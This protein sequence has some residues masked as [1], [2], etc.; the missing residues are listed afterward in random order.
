MLVA[1]PIIKGS[2]LLSIVTAIKNI[3]LL[4]ISVSDA[5]GEHISERTAVSRDG[6]ENVR[7]VQGCQ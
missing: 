3:N 6:L 4:T 7:C 2:A 1:S 5:P